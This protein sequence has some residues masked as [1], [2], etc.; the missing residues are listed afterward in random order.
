MALT[1]SEKIKHYFR[2][3]GVYEEDRWGN[4]KFQQNGELYRLKFQTN[5]IRKEVKVS[6]GE[7]VRVSSYN[8]KQLYRNLRAQ[9]K[10]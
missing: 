8:I 9:K 5:V 3:K 1:N 4:F 6:T 10:I 7:W 2:Q